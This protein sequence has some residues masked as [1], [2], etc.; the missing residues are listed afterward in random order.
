MKSHYFIVQPAASNAQLAK[1]NFKTNK[2]WKYD[3]S[4]GMKHK[5]CWDLSMLLKSLLKW[6]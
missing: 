3:D 1:I 6:H 4:A 2:L 5:E